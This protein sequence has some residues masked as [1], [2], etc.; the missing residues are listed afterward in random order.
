[1]AQISYKQPSQ[2]E[3]VEKPTV[4]TLRKIKGT[5]SLKDCLKTSKYR[6]C[7]WWHI[8][9]TSVTQLRHSQAVVKLQSLYKEQVKKIRSL[10]CNHAFTKVCRKQH[11]SQKKKIKAQKKTKLERQERSKL[12]QAVQVNVTNNCKTFCKTGSQS[13]TLNIFQFYNIWIPQ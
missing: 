6:Q 9:P 1:M 2:R 8:L 5:Y 3:D 7:F 12:Q 10:I 11:Q 13:K 4:R